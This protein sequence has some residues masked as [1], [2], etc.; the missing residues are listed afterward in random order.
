MIEVSEILEDIELR[1]QYRYD[2]GGK[3]LQIVDA[4]GRSALMYS[5][6]YWGER[7]LS[8]ILIQVFANISTMQRAR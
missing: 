8:T 7:L 2:L 4:A 6:T 1:T 3:I 5:M